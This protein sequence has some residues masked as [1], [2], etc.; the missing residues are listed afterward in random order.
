MK[1]LISFKPNKYRK[2]IYENLGLNMLVFREKWLKHMEK[3]NFS[4]SYWMQY[5]NWEN[6]YKN[7]P[8]ELELWTVTGLD[9][10][11]QED[12]PYDVFL[13]KLNE[14]GFT[15]P[16]F[17]T[18]LWLPE[19]FIDSPFEILEELLVFSPVPAPRFSK[20]YKT[21]QIGIRPSP[22]KLDSGKKKFLLHH[23]DLRPTETKI[24]FKSKRIVQKNNN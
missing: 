9:L 14:K 18:G 17:G 24:C 23:Y 16:P 11:I 13:S 10:E 15:T 6:I 2:D 5:L 12:V 4:D 22:V 8:D 20:S 19:V 21:Y 7:V 1:K 3:Y